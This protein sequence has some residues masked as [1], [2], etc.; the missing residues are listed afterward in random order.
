MKLFRSAIGVAALALC[1]ACG[2][3]AYDPLFAAIDA[4]PNDAPAGDTAQPHILVT[5]VDLLF[6]IDNSRSMGD[7]QAL[8]A[9][10]VPDLIGRF[11]T[12]YCVPAGNGAPQ[13]P[14]ADGSCPVG[15]RR[16]I[17]AVSDL[18]IGVVSSSLG[19]GGAEQ[20]GGAA[21]CS[22]AALEPRFNKFNS[23]NDDRGHLLN[24]TKPLAANNSGLEDAVTAANPTDGQGGNFLAWLPAVAANAAKPLPNVTPEPTSEALATDFSALV[25]GVQEFGCG[26][27]AQLESWYRFLVQPDP[28]DHLQLVD[29]P[30]GGIKK[31]QLVSVDATLLKQRHDFLRPDSLLVIVQITDEEDSWSDPLALGGRAWLTRAAQ[32]AGSPTG[33]M[34]RGTSE[35]AKSVDPGQP[36]TTGPNSP[37]CS[38][39][40]FAGNLANGTPIASDPS[41]TTS[42]GAGCA[43]YYT[44][45]QDGLNVRY[46]SDMKRRYGFDPQF[47]V[48]RYVSGLKAPRVPNREGEHPGGA[49]SYK[50]TPNCTNPIFAA[51]L[52]TN[53]NGELCNLPVGPR[54]PDLVYFA[55]IGGLPW[56]LLADGFGNFKPTLA[57]DDWRKLVGADPD[58]YNFTGI[59]PHMIESVLPRVQENAA[60]IP[61]LSAGLQPPTAGITADPFNGREWNTAKSALGLDLQYACTFALPTSK[62]C[63]DFATN[64]ACDCV[65]PATDPDGPPLCAPGESGNSLQVRGKAYP[66]IRELR[67]AQ[68]LGNQGIVASIC[69]KS[70][71]ESSPEFG[72]R[73]V[74]S[75]LLRRVAGAFAQ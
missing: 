15:T 28:Y 18:H 37:N 6:A 68:G 48:S 51:S 21:I 31:T 65:G 57:A 63:A 9:K 58:H 54:T 71:D 67:V 27:E 14:Q 45:Q 25:L 70:L 30:N 42:C 2:G 36:T 8:V 41:C 53:P 33:L 43:G 74:V 38:S 5:K 13:P 44:A 7:K 66:T 12:P 69:P 47:P 39:C 62:E 46:T 50:G 16:E 55:L 56:Q 26:L 17:P 22:P 73:P 10:A 32:F 34:P 60:S 29:D 1:A 59:D 4:G 35:C 49:G 20:A 52:P 61:Y 11:L 3:T 23:H 72:Y 24:R 75:Q 40:G 19:G 64:P